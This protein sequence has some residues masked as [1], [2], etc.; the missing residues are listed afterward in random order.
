MAEDLVCLLCVKNFA[1]L[2]V[3]YLKPMPRTFTSKQYF[4]QLNY[5]YFAPAAMMMVFAA[6][7]FGFVYS[8]K[9]VPV[10]EP[11]Q[12]PTLT[13]VLLAIVI[14][15][16]SASHYLYNFQLARLD[17]KL[18]L[19]QKLP[20]YIGILLVRSA[21][22]ELPSLAA[23]IVFFLTGNYYLLFIPLFTA[24]VFILLRPTTTS[25]AEDLKLSDKERKHLNNPEEVVAE[26]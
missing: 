6:V 9:T 10:A 3:Q 13:Y 22:M 7:V 20:K 15:G 14:I 4:S 11:N 25:V 17:P 12:V 2:R 18:D 8:G 21:C 5:F 26:K 16:F 24:L 1:Y 19:R 23:S